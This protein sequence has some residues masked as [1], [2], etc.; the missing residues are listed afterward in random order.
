[1]PFALVPSRIFITRMLWLAWVTPGLVTQEILFDKSSSQKINHNLKG[2]MAGDF[3]SSKFLS[4]QC[5]KKYRCF[6]KIFSGSLWELPVPSLTL[7]WESNSMHQSNQTKVQHLAFFKIN[8]VLTIDMSQFVFLIGVPRQNNKC[9]KPV[10]NNSRLTH[11]MS[12][13]FLY[14][15]S[16]QSVLLLVNEDFTASWKA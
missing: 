14:A 2:T 7:A 3:L 10:S 11:I 9:L 13:L 16:K 8:E 1:M 6:L 12:L 5:N 4:A 15:S